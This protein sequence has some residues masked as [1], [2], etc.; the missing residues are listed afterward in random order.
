[1]LP[2]GGLLTVA[3][4]EV[5]AT[6]FCGDDEDEAAMGLDVEELAGVFADTDGVVLATG[7]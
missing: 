7:V 6:V 2:E 5:T 4:T 1:V 3:A